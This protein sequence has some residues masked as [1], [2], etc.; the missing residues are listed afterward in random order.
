MKKFY[1]CTVVFMC[2]A[3]TVSAQ[4]F[5]WVGGNAPGAGW[6]NPSN[7]SNTSGGVGGF[8]VPDNPSHFVIFNTNAMV[9]VDDEAIDLAALSIVNNSRVLMYNAIPTETILHATTGLALFIEE[10]SVKMDSTTG[11]DTHLDT[12]FADNTQGIVDGTWGFDGFDPDYLDYAKFVLP[13]AAGLS[14]SLEINGTLYYGPNSKMPILTGNSPEYITFNDGALLDVNKNGDNII[15]ANYHPNS[16]VLIRGN[17]TA[18]TTISTNPPAIGNLV[19]DLPDLEI[20]VS[21]QLYNFI[22][23]GDVNV[24]N[25]NNIELTFMGTILSPTLAATV[26][27]NVMGDFNVSG[28]SNFV[29][30]SQNHANKTFV[31]DIAGDL[32]ADG[33]SFNIEKNAS[34]AMATSSTIVRVRGNLNHISGTFTSSSTYFSQSRDLYIVEMAGSTPQ[35]ITSHNGSF[36]NPSNSTVTLLINNPAG[37][38]LATPLTVGRL[39]FASPNR[40]IL[41]TTATNVLSIYNNSGIGSSRAVTGEANNGYVNGPVRRRM[42]STNNFRFPTGGGGVLRMVN[43]V[44]TSDNNTWFQVQYFGSGYADQSVVNPLQD[45]SDTEY[46][47]VQ[48][49]SGSANAT[50]GISLNGAYP[51]ATANHGIIIARYNGTDWVRADGTMIAPGNSTTGTAISAEQTEFGFF[52]LGR[53]NQSALPIDLLAFNARKLSGNNVLV[54]WKVTNESTPEKF[55]LMRSGNGRDF[56]SLGVVAG[57]PGLED[58]QFSD[59]SLPQGTSYYRLKMFDIDGTV[60]YSKV[61]AVMNG[62]NGVLLTSMM[63]TVVLNRARVNVS[64]SRNVTMQFVVT[65]MHGRIIHRQTESVLQGNQEIWLN[66]QA[67]ARGTYQVIGYY[68]GQRTGS[69]RFVKQ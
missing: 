52:T 69:I 43:I 3:M 64:S 13:T 10:G 16:T 11:E 48:R 29:L 31:L 2:L 65:D 18:G 27:V 1:V 6:S 59:N 19:I 23:Q 40:G 12:R 24:I 55:E 14:N 17:R 35:T 66:L 50:L 45:V 15:R 47:E 5:Y 22:I 32:N 58:Y 68:E 62:G 41:N 28:N 21:L 4:T 8:G 9:L 56:S 34:G 54:T 61:I 38:T 60:S 63:P 49:I 7:W 30:G 57:A 46:W 37:V 53:A 42:S 26:T 20:P 67:L 33:N 51:G 25:T 39:S 44:P 36:N